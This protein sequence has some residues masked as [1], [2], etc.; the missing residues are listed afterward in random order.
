[1]KTMLDLF[2]SSRF[3]EMPLR[4]SV[5][6]AAVFCV[7]LAL[8]GCSLFGDDEAPEPDPN[9]GD[10]ERV[11]LEP[12]DQILRVEIGQLTDGL[13]VT[14]FGLARSAGYARPT[15]SPRRQGRPGPDGF[16]EFDFQAQ[17]PDPGL[18]LPRGDARLRRLRADRLLPGRVFE[19]AAGIRVFGLANASAIRFGADGAR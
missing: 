6:L 8:G 12:V 15:L 18:E 2:A 19:G 14:A 5:L 9:L 7:P 16:V 10:V 4:R 1:M 17:P 3:R 13:V 11:R